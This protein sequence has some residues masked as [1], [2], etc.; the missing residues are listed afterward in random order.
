[1]CLL[2]QLGF[3]KIVPIVFAKLAINTIMRP[4]LNLSETLQKQA[5][6]NRAEFDA[7]DPASRARAEGYKAGT[8][9]RISRIGPR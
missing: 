9:A 5:D 1:V 4:V 8:Y 3:L 7:L 6:I 2:L